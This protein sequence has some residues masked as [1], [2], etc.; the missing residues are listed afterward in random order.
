MNSAPGLAREC[1]VFVRHLVGMAP[2]AYV[3]KAY[4]AAH[5]ARA[6]AFGA[7]SPFGAFTVRLASRSSFTAR[8]ADAW[9]RLFAP[10]GVLR[11][12][13][14]LL[15]AILETA[16]PFHRELDAVRGSVFS[17]ALLLAAGVGGWALALALG[18]LVLLPARLALG[19]ER[20]P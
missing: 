4:E 19:G 10:R 5:A 12:K 13:L 3:L 1:N 2:N 8:S 17:Q 18:T 9:C 6:E 14:V 7:M 11:R 20:R 16:P 15:L